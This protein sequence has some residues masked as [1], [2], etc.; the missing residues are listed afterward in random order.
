[1]R[2]SIFVPLPARLDASFVCPHREPCTM[3]GLPEGRLEFK[4]IARGLQRWNLEL[5]LVQGPSEQMTLA[6]LTKL[7]N[8]AICEARRQYPGIYVDVP[9]SLAHVRAHRKR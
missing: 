9:A 6:E 7:L 1:M 3:A 4:V 5:E 8:I 2:P